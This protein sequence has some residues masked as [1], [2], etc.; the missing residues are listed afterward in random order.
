MSLTAAPT[1]GAERLTPAAAAGAPHAGAAHAPSPAQLAASSAYCEQLT[2]R[3]ARNFYYG[4]KLL[5]E[6]KRSAMFALYAYMRLLDDIADDDNG[7]PIQQ[8]LEALEAWRAHTHAAIEGVMPAAS[9]SGDADRVAREGAAMWPA[10]AAMARSSGLPRYV[11]DDVID[12]QRQDLEGIQFQRFDAL[13]D[14]CYRVAGTVG[15]A[16]IYVWGFDG[17]AEAEKLA[18]YRGVAFQLTNVLRDLHEDADRGRT[19]LPL[20][21]LEAMGVSEADLR[22]GRGGKDFQRLMRFQIARAESYYDRSTG[23][24][25]RI[26]RDSRSTLIAMTEIYRGLL[27]KVARAPER[28]LHER[29]SLSLLTKLRI[30][31]RASRAAMR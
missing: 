4:L 8:R 2:R 12:G 3:A 17:S 29:V 1:D 10:F 24:E 11:L 30:G 19:Y 13:Y 6:P 15:L 27:H 18:I 31:W 7:R 26:D 5:P 14:Y 21:D 22:A 9:D 25:D 28:V 16:S 23:L 20:E